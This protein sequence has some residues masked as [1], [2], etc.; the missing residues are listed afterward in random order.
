M[1]RRRQQ[2]TTL[3]WE[4][5]AARSATSSRSGGRRSPHSK[6]SPLRHGLGW[7]IRALLDLA[8]GLAART[9]A[10]QLLLIVLAAFIAISLDPAV[11]SLVRRPAPRPAVRGPR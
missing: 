11:A 2:P 5:R 8:V 10:H 4:Q 3:P 1:P 9:V 6:R 7:T